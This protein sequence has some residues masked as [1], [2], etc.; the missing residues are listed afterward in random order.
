[1]SNPN[2]YTANIEEVKSFLMEL[3]NI[4]S[5]KNYDLDIL[6]KKKNENEED[7][8]TTENTMLDL[9]YDT[10]DVK[11]ELMALNEKEYI[12]TII[13]DKDCNRPPFWVFGKEINKKEVYIKVKIR[14][15]RTNKVFCVSFHYARFPL[16]ERPFK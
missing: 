13:D 8:Y 1:M 3:K 7:P 12:E 10:E 6:D 15:R 5:S 9:N 11:N 4:L 2:S 16:K 14:N